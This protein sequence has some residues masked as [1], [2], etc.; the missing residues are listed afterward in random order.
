MIFTDTI[1][2]LPAHA[3]IV[4]AV[5]ILMPLASLAVIGMIIRKDW[6]HEYRWQLLAL[7]VVSTA[8]VPLATNSGES[9][10]GRV[11]QLATTNKALVQAHV[12]A[13]EN[14][15]PFALLLL[16]TTVLILWR[17]SRLKTRIRTIASA[18]AV[19]AALGSIAEVVI[20]GHSG[21]KSVWANTVANTHSVPGN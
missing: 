3:L 6:Q 18:L 19:V 20:I 11:N 2:G 4:H 13:G 17:G 1:F 5:V 7:V 8:S 10:A 9:L 15:T 16:L 21:A 14:L 12:N